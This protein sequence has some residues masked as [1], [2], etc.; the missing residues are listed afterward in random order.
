MLLAQNTNMKLHLTAQSER[1]KEATKSANDFI[2]I[3]LT[4]HRQ[5]VGQIELYLNHDS[6]KDGYDNDEWL[7]KYKRNPDSEEE[8]WNIIAQGNI[9]PI[10]VAYLNKKVF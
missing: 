10:N 4:V 3:D 1:G 6:E 2:I 5:V 8:D 7:I 9:E